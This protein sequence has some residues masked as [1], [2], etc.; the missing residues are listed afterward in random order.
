MVEEAVRVHIEQAQQ[1]GAR[2]SDPGAQYA[3]TFDI[4]LTELRPMVATPGDPRNGITIDRLQDRVMVDI[5]YGGSC[6]GGKRT[7][8][9]LYAQILRQAVDQGKKVAPNVDLYIQFGS[10][11][12]RRYAEDRGYIDLFRAAGARLVNPSC[13]ACI[14]AGPGVSLNDSQVT[15]SAINRNFPGRSGPGDVYLGSPLVVAA[16]AIA[17]Y[18]IEPRELEEILDGSAQAAASAN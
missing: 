16:S 13:G 12:I 15:I 6:T 11:D 1:A 2:K 3:A 9:D 14:K 18:I 8:M 7:D 5:A 10:Q 4:D 17:G